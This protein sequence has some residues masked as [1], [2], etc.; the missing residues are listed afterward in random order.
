MNRCFVGVS[1]LIL[2]AS[3]LS[4]APVIQAVQNAASN[5]RPG[6]PNAGIAQGSI[7]VVYGTGL[8]PTATSVAPAA[9]QNSLL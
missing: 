9:F 7:F 5:I 2:L 8:G 1:S 6:L 4:A 3:G